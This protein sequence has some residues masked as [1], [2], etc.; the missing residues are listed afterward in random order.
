MQIQVKYSPH[1]KEA[2]DQGKP[3]VALESTIITHGMPWPSNLESA[4]AV[5]EV[6][7]EEGAVPAT[8]A[9][10][11]GELRAG[12]TR[13]ELETLAKTR[14]AVKASRRDLPWLVAKGLNGGT[15]V[16]ATMIIAALAGIKVFATGGI[17]GVHRGWQEN[18]DISADLMEL[19][20]TDVAV[21]CAGVKS[22]LDIPATLEYLETLGVPVLTYRSAE[23]PA[24]FS[25]KSGC[26]S[27]MIADSPKE[28]A[29]MLQAKWG[30]G[31]KGGAIIANPIPPEKD[32][33]PQVINGSILQ[34]LAEAREKDVRGKLVTPFLLARVLELTGGSSLAANMAL[35]HNNARLAAKISQAMIM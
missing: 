28:I 7:R 1:V 4:L 17:G 16:A 6:V 13:E 5:E 33:D 31:L 11:G 32:M 19:A 14:D 8:M 26:L 20:T 34:A 35:V 21:V 22:I 12:L 2:L 15:T 9:I 24:F 27:P 29:A 23:F 30:L 25:S 18:L 3:L 10:L